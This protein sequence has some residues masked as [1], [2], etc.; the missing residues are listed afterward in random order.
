MKCQNH[1]K[2]RTLFGPA[3]LI[4]LVSMLGC[5]DS[6][7]RP[8]PERTRE[9]P[10]FWGKS[11]YVEM[12]DN[13]TGAVA[14][15]QYPDIG[16]TVFKVPSTGKQHWNIYENKGDSSFGPDNLVAYAEVDPIEAVV[17]RESIP[18]EGLVSRILQARLAWHIFTPVVEDPKRFAEREIVLTDSRWRLVGQIRA[19]QLIVA[20]PVEQKYKAAFAESREKLEADAHK[21]GGRTGI[22]RI[23]TQVETFSYDPL[24]RRM[25]RSIEVEFYGEDGLPSRAGESSEVGSLT[26][27]DQSAD[28]LAD[29]GVT[30]VTKAISKDYDATPPKVTVAI[31][32]EAQ[33]GGLGIKVDRWEPGPT[34]T[35]GCKIRC[36]GQAA[37]QVDHIT[38]QVKYPSGYNS[39]L[40]KVQF[41]SP[42]IVRPSAPIRTDLGGSP[43]GYMAE[44]K[45]TVYS[46][47]NRAIG[48]FLIVL[49]ESEK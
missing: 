40:Y 6:D 36:I 37:V 17:D 45:V 20:G 14:M 8:S 11:H 43:Q 46:S 24:S 49:K 19:K 32:Q 48:P 44:L 31:D 2:Q 18:Q 34:H 26:Q 4:A 21:L 30:Q 28:R 33:H 41:T 27:D 16:V 39:Q 23:L 38:W 13:Q 5:S 42:R 22:D 47:G 35:I 3:L 9:Y 25:G 7:E 1:T 15:R 29:V 12:K 10:A